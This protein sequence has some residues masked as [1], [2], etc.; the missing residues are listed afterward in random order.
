VIEIS[1]V[2]SFCRQNTKGQRFAS[3]APCLK[4]LDFA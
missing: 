1:G 2:A 4:S 3:L